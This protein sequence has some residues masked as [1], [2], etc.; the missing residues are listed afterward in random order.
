MYNNIYN[1]FED[2]YNM[3]LFQNEIQIVEKPKNDKNQTRL[4]LHI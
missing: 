4:N 3:G 1:T 2:S